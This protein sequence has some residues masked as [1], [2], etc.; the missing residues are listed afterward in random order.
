MNPGLFNICGASPL[1]APCRCCRE[2]VELSAWRVQIT[3]QS[4]GRRERPPLELCRSHQQPSINPI[5][6]SLHPHIHPASSPPSY[7]HAPLTTTPPATT[8]RTLAR[9]ADRPLALPSHH[10]LHLPLRLPPIPPRHAQR[11]QGVANS[12][13]QASSQGYRDN[14]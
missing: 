3:W 12:S 14:D 9:T 6:I 4:E 2:N 11:L 8:T 5:S 7:H 10:R 1:P 13:G